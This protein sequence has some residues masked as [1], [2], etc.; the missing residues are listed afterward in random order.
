MSLLWIDGFN[1]YGTNGSRL[2]A[3]AAGAYDTLL[4]NS[5]TVFV[6]QPAMGGKGAQLSA[7]G[8]EGFALAKAYPAPYSSGALGVGFH[9]IYP[10]SFNTLDFIVFMSS[11][12][13]VLYRIQLNEGT[14]KLAI[15]NGAGTTLATS[16][17]T[18]ANMTY[19]HVE[20][21][22]IIAGSS[23]GS[24][25]VRIGGD[26]F[27]AATGITTN[28]TAVGQIAFDQ[29]VAGG[30]SCVFTMGN[31]YLWDGAGSVN[32]DWIGEKKV[33]TALPSADTV[34]ADWALS[35]GTSGYDLI[36]D[37]PAVDA[38]R[39]L[40]SSTVGDVSIFE[41]ADVVPASLA[42]A[43]VMTVVRAEKTDSGAGTLEFGPVHAGVPSLASKAQ[44]NAQF[45]WA[46]KVDQ[47]NPSTSAPWTASEANA[48]Q[49][50]LRRAA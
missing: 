18:L 16:A 31:L 43:G 44:T 13:T 21:K 35:T 7:T 30:D 4:N 2:A 12:G 6:D 25:E 37:V 26:T 40:E 38:T 5:G 45:L 50:E 32:N 11:T 48:A 29:R 15:L 3:S 9:M 36:N 22:M 42:I 19:Y 14:G 8:G 49:I 27:V 39:Y 24:I 33:Y 20:A 46:A 10:V 17:G 23:A 34:D 47:L 41:T 28:G 1:H